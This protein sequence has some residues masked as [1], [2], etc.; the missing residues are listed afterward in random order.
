MFRVSVCTIF[1]HE[2]SIL[3]ISLWYLGLWLKASVFDDCRGD[4]GFR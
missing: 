2:L 4:T 3:G 1:Q